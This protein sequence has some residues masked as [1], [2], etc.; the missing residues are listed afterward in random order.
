MLLGCQIRHR[1]VLRRHRGHSLGAPAAAAAAAAGPPASTADGKGRAWTL[2]M[3]SPYAAAMP[4]PHHRA[5]CRRESCSPSPVGLPARRG[6]VA[7]R[8]KLFQAAATARYAV[9]MQSA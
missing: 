5:C 8:R 2:V 4:R 7:Q 1:S 9:A 6:E 3:A